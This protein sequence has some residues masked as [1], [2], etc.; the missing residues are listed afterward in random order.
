VVSEKTKKEQKRAKRRAQRAK[1][2]KVQPRRN[3]DRARQRT[4]RTTQEALA[5]EDESRYRLEN[6]SNRLSIDELASFRAFSEDD[7]LETMDSFSHAEWLEVAK[8][9]GATSEGLI[10]T[11]EEEERYILQKEREAILAEAGLKKGDKQH[12]K[13]SPQNSRLRFWQ[14]W[15]ITSALRGAPD[16]NRKD[17]TAYLKTI[18]AY[19]KTLG[20]N[21]GPP[22]QE[23]P[24]AA[25]MLLQ[26]ATQAETAMTAAEAMQKMLHSDIIPLAKFTEGA[27]TSEIAKLLARTAYERTQFDIACK[28]F[29]ID[30]YRADGKIRTSLMSRNVSAYWWQITGAYAL[31]RM[32]ED[33]WCRGGILADMVGLGKTFTLAIAILHVSSTPV[34]L[35]PF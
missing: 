34:P 8:R 20:E 24:T 4:L 15:I 6:L 26:N 28:Y 35:I 17:G 11:S 19:I 3:A 30:P 10:S 14:L 23:D 22:E 13:F 18:Q 16:E 31:C 7:W 2:T 25:E 1:R 29:R 27:D 21:M 5:I 9:A 12:P 32:H 33:G